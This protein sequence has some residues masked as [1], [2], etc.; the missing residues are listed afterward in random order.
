[1]EGRAFG[2]P[3]R[4]NLPDPKKKKKEGTIASLPPLDD[5]PS[6]LVQATA[7]KDD[8]TAPIVYADSTPLSFRD[9]LSDK[10]IRRRLLLVAF[11]IVTVVTISVS[12]VVVQGG[13]SNDDMLQAETPSPTAAPSTSPTFISPEVLQFVSEISG[14]NAVNDPQSA[15][16]KAVG[17]MS[18]FDTTVDGYGDLFAQRYTMA[19]LF[20]SLGGEE[21]LEQDQWMNPTKHECDWSEAVF[22]VVD[23]TGRR[24]VSGLD[25]TRNGM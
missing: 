11:L 24:L 13:S 15:Q 12:L 5:E 3:R 7:V 23:G 4:P 9:L 6:H 17:W 14:E 25:L 21:W 1:M 2:A 22:C 8:S 10:S 20:Y 19:T 16:F 18:T